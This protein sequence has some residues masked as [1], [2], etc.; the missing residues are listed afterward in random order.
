MR[1]F[2]CP[3]RRGSSNE[4]NE[5]DLRCLQMVVGL[6]LIRN[7]D[8]SSWELWRA[9]CLLSESDHQANRNR[10]GEFRVN[11]SRPGRIDQSCGRGQISAEVVAALPSVVR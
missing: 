10:I 3:D 4:I 6:E 7:L 8:Q 11:L 5:L 9:A 2:Q 1:E